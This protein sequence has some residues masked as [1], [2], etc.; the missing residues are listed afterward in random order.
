MFISALALSKHEKNM[1]PLLQDIPLLG[2]FFF[3]FFL[4]GSIKNT[5][6]IM[7]K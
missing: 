7:Q 6:K 3:F 1:G 2:L 4:F 5:V